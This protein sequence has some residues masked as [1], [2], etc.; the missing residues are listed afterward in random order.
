MNMNDY[1]DIIM[2]NSIPELIKSVNDKLKDG[3]WKLYGNLVCEKKIGMYYQTLT[4]KTSN[5]QMLVD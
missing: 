2:A 1:Y 3:E 5:T 4:R